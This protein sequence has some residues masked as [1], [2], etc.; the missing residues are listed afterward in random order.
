MKKIFCILMT[1]ILISLPFFSIYSSATFDNLMKEDIYSD[2]YLLSSMD[3]GTIVLNKNAD[4][5]NPCPALNKILTVA[6]AL[7]NT[8]DIDKKI[9]IT[10]KML[11]SANIRWAVT[12]KLQPGEKISLRDLLYGIMV[13]GA[14]DACLAV[15]FEIGGSIEGFMEMV[16]SYTASLGCKDT[17]MKNPTGF[18]EDGQYTT[19]NDISKIMADIVKTPVFMEI[20]GAKN[21][22]IQAT[23][24]TDKRKYSSTNKLFYSTVPTYYYSYVNGGK[25]GATDN[26]G[27]C[28]ISTATKDGYTYLA[29]VMQG[30]VK[31]INAN[32]KNINTATYDSKTMFKWAFS[33]IKFKVVATQNHVVSVM[34]V[35]AGSEADRVSLVPASEISSLV[36]HMADQDGVLITPIEETVPEEIYAPINKGDV[37][38]QAKIYYAGEE[39]TTIDLVAAESISLSI[40]RLILE[41]VKNVLTSKIFLA[42]VIILVSLIVIYIIF[43][44]ADNM[45]AKKNRIHVV[46]RK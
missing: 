2:I 7:K 11:D 9:K 13:Q 46:G 41:K 6:V 33:N 32:L 5:K 16:N 39:L 34:D 31:D 42:I 36:P 22:E 4:R 20:F 26:S 30:E 44:I 28:M 18:D 10:Q 15:A 19:A 24:L 21:C 12:M 29:V 40:P 27:Y 23:N 43:V 8:D 1:V 14:N 38:C 35:I 37:I 17:V 3:D 45:K 25:N